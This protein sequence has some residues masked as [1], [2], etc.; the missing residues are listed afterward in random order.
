[1]IAER[2]LVVR[3]RGE[4]PGP[5]AVWLVQGVDGIEAPT[6]EGRAGQAG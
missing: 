5:A 2:K 1:M 6:T 3:S 4:G